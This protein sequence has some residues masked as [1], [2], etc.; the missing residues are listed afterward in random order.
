M[1]KS[2]LFVFELEPGM[3]TAEDVFTINGQLLVPINTVLDNISINKFRLYN[4]PTVA[5]W[6]KNAVPYRETVGTYSERIKSSK[7]FQEFK[8][9]YLENIGN[10][11]TLVNDMVVKNEPLNIQALIDTTATL[12]NSSSTNLQIF[13]MLQNMREFD[14][15]TFAHCINVSLICRVFGRWLRLSDEDIDALTLS[16]LLHD[17]GKLS[18]PEKI[19]TKPGKLTNEEYRIMKTHTLDGYKTL[20]NYDL[21]PR[22]KEACIFHHE[23]CDGTGYPYNLK[24]DQIPDFAKIVSIADVYDA[25]TAKR[26]YRG[27][28]CPFTVIKHLGDEGYSKYDPK[29]LLPFLENVVSTYIHTTVLLNDGRTGEVIMINR[30]SLSRP[31]IQCGN[32]FIDLSVRT[33][34]EILEI[35]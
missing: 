24:G 14:D 5:I 33:D 21:D 17:I 18:T 25:M 16:G 2:S 20:R 34:L 31:F 19:L 30:N 3:T 6:E 22:V 35:I 7:E 8:E 29:F 15:S 23:R 11:Q 12:V 4:I 27:P 10:F 13:D 28:L 1:N 9:D 32:E 26:V